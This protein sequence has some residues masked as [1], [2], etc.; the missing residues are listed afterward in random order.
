MY[1]TLSTVF[2]FVF[3]CVCV[4]CVQQHA[5]RLM[6]FGQI[7]KV[8]EMEPLPSNKQP[9]KYPW[10]DKEGVCTCPP[11]PVCL[12]LLFSISPTCPLVCSCEG[13]SIG[14]SAPFLTWNL[15]W[16]SL[17]WVSWRTFRHPTFSNMT[18]HF[19][20]HWV[21]FLHTSTDDA[22][23]ITDVWRKHH[24]HMLKD[25][26]WDFTFS[27]HCNPSLS[28]TQKNTLALVTRC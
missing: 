19:W 20:K 10:S 4:L 23:N 11:P 18:W 16:G 2:L 17:I 12:R 24:K 15:Q 7:Y 22:V 26:V 1:I 5:L 9:Q 21:V 25:A 6:A 28:V 3:S 8:L 14:P 13:L 27:F